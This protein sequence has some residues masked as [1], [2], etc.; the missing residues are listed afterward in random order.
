VT[1]SAKPSATASAKPAVKS[2]TCVK[3]KLKKVVSGVK[4]VCPKDYKLN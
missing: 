3:G 4:P 2:I 1:P